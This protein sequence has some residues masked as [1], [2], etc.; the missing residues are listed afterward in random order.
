MHSTKSNGLAAANNQPAETY[1]PKAT[2]PNYPTGGRLS[3]VE[4][5]LIVRFAL[6]GHVVRRGSCND[7]TV[8]KFGHSRYCQD[9]SELQE[10]SVRLGVCHA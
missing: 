7:Y 1:T 3:K 2:S 6:A 10:F 8:S 9:L 4:A 5:T